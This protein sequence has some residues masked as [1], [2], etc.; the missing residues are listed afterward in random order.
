MSTADKNTV[1]KNTEYINKDVSMLKTND[2]AKSWLSAQGK[3]SPE[4]LQLIKEDL[5]RNGSLSDVQGI[6]SSYD[7][8]ILMLNLILQN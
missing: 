1:A 4:E 6:I 3:L 2:Q 8:K 7:T 5:L